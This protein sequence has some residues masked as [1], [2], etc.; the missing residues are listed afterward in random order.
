Q[1]SVG[2]QCPECTRTGAQRVVTSRQI[3]GRGVGVVVVKALIGLNVAAYVLAL[4][5]PSS[6]ITGVRIGMD[7]VAVEPGVLY[8]PLVA[9]GEWWRVLTGAFLHAGLLHLGMNMWL[10]WLL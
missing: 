7:V 9:L 3:F 10:L 5:A 6:M 2:F 1:A 8:G 4:A